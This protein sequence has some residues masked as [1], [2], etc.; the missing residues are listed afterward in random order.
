MLAFPPAGR[1]PNNNVQ[2]NV[3]APTIHQFNEF[4]TGVPVRRREVRIVDG[5]FK[6]LF[7]RFCT[8]CLGDLVTENLRDERDIREGVRDALLDVDVHSD[9]AE[10]LSNIYLN[11]IRTLARNGTLMVEPELH[12]RPALVQPK[13]VAQVV[14]AL[15]CKLGLDAKDRAVPGNVSLVRREA[16][17]IMRSWNVRDADA[18]MHLAWVEKCFF[19]ES[20]HDRLPEWRARA[21]RQG[22]LLRWLFKDDPP[23]YD[24]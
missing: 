7:L 12:V 10:A 18:S 3:A 23:T 19:E 14:V 16:A 21:A 5:W 15:R 20:V 4:H 1:Q 6:D 13:F 2:G 17:K 24:F 8:C 9:S 11:P 22:K